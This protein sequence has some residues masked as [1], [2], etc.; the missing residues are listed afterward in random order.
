MVLSVFFDKDRK[1]RN[2]WWVAVFFLILASITFPVILLS[3]YYSFEVTILLQAIIVFATSVICQ[4]LRGKPFNELFGVFNLHWLKTLFSGLLIG[5]VLMFAPAI[6]LYASGWV[7]FQ[8]Q[9]VDLM[10]MLSITMVFVSVAFAEELLFRGFIFQRLI[11][12]IGQWPAQFIIAGLFLLTHFNNPGMTGSTKMF[13][14]INIFLASVLFGLAVIRTKSLAMPLGIHF[15]ANWVQ[16]VLLGFGVSGNEQAGFFKPVIKKSANWLTGGSFGLEAS[17]PGLVCVVIT[18]II[19][20]KW[21][22]LINK[23]KPLQFKPVDHV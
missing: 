6:F 23:N 5:A 20:Y 1:L 22:P 13:A 3:Q 17:L 18:I 12:G 15:M 7:S 11:A 2:G 9:M 10:H 14:G 8:K 19:L 4:L 21:K 16:G